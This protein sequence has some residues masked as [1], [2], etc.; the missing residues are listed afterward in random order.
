MKI[1]MASD[2]GGFELK[3]ELKEYLE[4]K[5][6]EI[7]DLGTDSADST[8]YPKWGKAC[9]EYVVN[10]NADKGIVLCGTGIGISIAANKVKGAR[11]ALVTS[12]ETA[13]M[14]AE[15]NQANLLSIG[16]RTTSVEDAKKYI[17]IWLSTPPDL[18]ERHVKR[19][20]MLNE[21]G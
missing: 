20:G 18:A 4:G 3:A 9:S 10:G 11:C 13:K 1:A 12:E 5:G 16:G 21:M 14:A 8:D 15:H 6:Y 2:H 17:D 7:V 19:V